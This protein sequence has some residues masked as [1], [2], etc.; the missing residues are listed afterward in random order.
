MSYIES[1]IFNTTWQQA[2]VVKLNEL[3]F[4]GVISDSQYNDL[5]SSMSS[6]N[7]PP[8]MIRYMKQIGVDSVG[9]NALSSTFKLPQ[10]NQID[11]S[12]MPNLVLPEVNLGSDKDFTSLDPDTGKGSDSDGGSIGAD[13]ITR[14]PDLVTDVPP[15]R[16]DPDPDSP[17]P[18]RPDSGTVVTPPDRDNIGLGDGDG[19]GDPNYSDPDSVSGSGGLFFGE[20][21]IFGSNLVKG[22]TSLFQSLISKYTDSTVTGGEEIRNQWDLDKMSLA[23]EF[24]AQQAEI[25]RDWQQQMYEQ[26]NSLSGKIHQAEQAGVNPLFAVTGNAVSPMSANGGSPSGAIASGSGQKSGSDILSSLASLIGL[27]AQIKKVNAETKAIETNTDISLKKLGAE[28][29]NLESSTSLNLQK[30]VESATSIEKIKSDINLN[31]YHAELFAEQVQYLIAQTN[32]INSIREPE[33]RL[34]VAQATIADWQEKNKELFKGIELGTDVLSTLSQI[35][36]GIFN[37][38]TGRMFTDS[39]VVVPKGATVVKPSGIAF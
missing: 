18:D 4:Q 22:F 24:S 15:S 39:S 17:L 26:Y 19:D 12:S 6:F 37:A 35:G 1:P 10:F 14:Y 30:V 27:K 7:A 21:G 13:K 29:S 31:D 28:L 33:K 16:I 20:D 36:L 9:V 8:D 34:K 3:R 23:N 32:Y 2:V 38:K 25:S 11:S 5:Y